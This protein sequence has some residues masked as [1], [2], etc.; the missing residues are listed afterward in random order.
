[1]FFTFVSTEGASA[2]G[3]TDGVDEVFNLEVRS[4]RTPGQIQI[5]SGSQ[6][7]TY[8]AVYKWTDADSKSQYSKISNLKTITIQSG[9][10]GEGNNPISVPITFSHLNLTGKTDVVVQIYRSTFVAST[11][12]QSVFQKVGEIA[13]IKSVDTGT[14]LDNVAEADLKERFFLFGHDQTNSGSIMIEHENRLVVANGENLYFSEKP[15]FEREEAIAFRIDSV[16]ILPAEIRSLSSLDEKIIAITENGIF[17]IIIP[18]GGA[19]QVRK[20][21][22]LEN[23]KIN[24][25]SIVPFQYGVIFQTNYG[26]TLLDRGLS[27]KFIGDDIK[28]HLADHS[29]VEGYV[30]ESRQEIYL[31]TN[32]SNVNLIYNYLYNKWTT[33][34]INLVSELES[35]NGE[36]L[37]LDSTGSLLSDKNDNKLSITSILKTGDIDLSGAIQGF[38]RLLSMTFLGEF[39]DFEYIRIEIFK[40]H[41][42]TPEVNFEITPEDA[43]HIF[44]GGLPLGDMNVP[45]G[46]EPPISTHFE[47]PMRIGRISSFSLRFTI[48]GNRA[49][50]FSGLGVTGIS[51]SDRFFKEGRKYS[52][53]RA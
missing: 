39:R 51:D 17:A 28:K 6:I 31:R 32:D 34:E 27:L 22:S 9:R 2:V 23:Y 48:R 46:Y 1:M 37:R 30:N 12:V 36:T 5:S 11:L 44:G 41:L 33:N 40:D 52:A 45:L 38:N 24:K 4:G 16:Q 43:E 21:Q 15:V 19:L 50:K 3:F 53:T 47:V 10:I 29:I 7:V 49:T 14:F 26:I 13:N 25:N 20:V 8:F 18:D 42:G 35:V